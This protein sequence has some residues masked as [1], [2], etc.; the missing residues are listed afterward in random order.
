M[1][2][3]KNQIRGMIINYEK[4]L[5]EYNL[6]DKEKEQCIQKIKSLKRLLSKAKK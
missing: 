6:S 1:D 4:A 2:A 5:K 3:T